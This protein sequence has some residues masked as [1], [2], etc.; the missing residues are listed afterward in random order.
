MDIDRFLDENPP[1][2]AESQQDLVDLAEVT[3]NHWAKQNALFAYNRVM[4]ISERFSYQSQLLENMASSG[5]RGGAARPL[6]GVGLARI[7]VSSGTSTAELEEK[8]RQDGGAKNGET[9]IDGP[10]NGVP[11]GVMHIESDVSDDD[12]QTDAAGAI[13][14]SLRY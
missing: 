12:E 7:P 9:R 4:E 11:G 6:T 5:Q 8:L 1:P 10:P 13:Y 14:K 3:E 2:S